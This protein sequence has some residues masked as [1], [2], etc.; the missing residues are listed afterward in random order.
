MIVLGLT[1][2]IACGKSGISGVLREL[3]ARIVDGDVLSR[4]LTAPGGAALPGI[5][6]LF[7]DRVFREDGTL[8]RR[9]L[10]AIVF[11]DSRAMADYDA[12][13]RPMLLRLITDAVRDAEREGAGV[14]VLDMPLL[15]EAGLDRL[16]DLVWCA[17][18]PEETQI[19][20]L[21]ERDGFD[22][23]TALQRIRSQL[24][25]SEKAARADLVIDTDRPPEETAAA[26]R[27]AWARAFPAAARMPDARGDDRP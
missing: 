24:P 16:C 26:V 3:G 14:C 21:R 9:G 22:R 1:G 12:L 8:D 20:R 27:E 2:G 18:V 19:R 23:E 17:W 13:I 4:E 15:Y 11:A 10:G 5:R 6:A 25:A 7:G